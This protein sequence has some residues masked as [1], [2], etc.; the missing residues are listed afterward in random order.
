[1]LQN[2]LI[3][4]LDPCKNRPPPNLKEMRRHFLHAARALIQLHVFLLEGDKKLVINIEKLIILSVFLSAMNVIF[5]F[6]SQFAVSCKELYSLAEKVCD[7][8]SLSSNS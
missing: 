3:E 1:M 2:F 8:P 4:G 6:G 7:E 5:P